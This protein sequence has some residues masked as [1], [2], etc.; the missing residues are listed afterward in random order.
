MITIPFDEQEYAKLKQL[1]KVSPSDG[2]PI[3]AMKI[4]DALADA[5][6]L[7][8]SL[9]RRMVRGEDAMI[10]VA[11]RRAAAYIDQTHQ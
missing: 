9:N 6:G 8:L 4:L 11:E 2:T 3:T 1:C 7:K 10:H 5:N